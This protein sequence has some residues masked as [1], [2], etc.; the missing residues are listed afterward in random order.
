MVCGISVFALDNWIWVI[1]FLIGPLIY[2]LGLILG[3][4]LSSI[5]WCW[6]L[7]CWI[8]V[9]F[10]LGRIAFALLFVWVLCFQVGILTLCWEREE[11]QYI[12]S[13]LGWL[14]KAWAMSGWKGRLPKE[15][16]IFL[17]IYIRIS[18]VK[19]E[20]KIGIGNPDSLF[21][22]SVL[23]CIYLLWGEIYFGM[24]LELLRDYNFCWGIIV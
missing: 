11:A 1:G 2:S 7:A 8:D 15:L 6:T 5:Y 21:S 12:G 10:D 3:W 20:G 22:F 18:S 14:K 17:C 13:N 9:W 24:F 4:F 16:E 19:M 23:F